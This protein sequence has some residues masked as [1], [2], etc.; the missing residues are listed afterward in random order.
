MVEKKTYDTPILLLTFNRPKNVEKQIEI[1]NKIRPKYLFLFSDGPRKNKKSDIYKVSQ[2]RELLNNKI[3]WECSV[4]RKFENN[5]L[6]CGKGVSSAITWFFLNVNE[7]LII[8]DDCL[9][10]LSFFDFAE[11]MLF[12]YRNNYS[13]AGITADYRLS[14]KNSTDYGLIPFPLIWG[15][16]TWKRS[17]DG[18]SF[19]LKQYRNQVLPHIIDSKPKNQRIFWKNNFDKIYNSKRP[20]TWDFQ[21]S[22]LVFSKGQSFI[23]P[24][25][26]LVTNIGFDIEATHTKTDSEFANK[27]VGK[28]LKPYLQKFDLNEYSNYLSKNIF[29]KQNLLQK[30]IIKFRFYLRK[31][32]LEKFEKTFY[33]FFK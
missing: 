30:I 19:N 22:Y 6:G 27:K 32:I 8:E 29:I 17:W 10:S 4:Q 18:Y 28:I 13:I 26:N 31:Y 5:N 24:F 23:H 1:L 15:W 21:F 33:K 14:S 7:G 20:F 16:A 25:T 9:L 11:E 2:S 12:K 3:D